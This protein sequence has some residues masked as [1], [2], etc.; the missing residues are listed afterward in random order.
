[1]SSSTTVKPF[2]LVAFIEVPA[3][4]KVSC[5]LGPMRLTDVPLSRLS[6]GPSVITRTDL[7]RPVLSVTDQ[8]TPYRPTVSLPEPTDA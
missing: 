5:T 4:S 1:M 6:P 8:V 2:R 7:L 3:R